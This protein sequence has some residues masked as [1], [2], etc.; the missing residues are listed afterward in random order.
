V[1]VNVRNWIEFRVEVL[2]EN[3][4]FLDCVLLTD[5]GQ[6]LQCELLRY[7]GPALECEVLTVIGLILL[8]EILT[9]KEHTVKCELLKSRR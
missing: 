2:T 7:I 6:I 9:E 4:N 1:R 3:G 8:F 5:S